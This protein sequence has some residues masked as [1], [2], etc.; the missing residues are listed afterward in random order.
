MLR[1]IIGLRTVPARR[2]VRLAYAPKHPCPVKACVK[3]KSI[4]PC[5]RVS[6][7]SICGISFHI[8]PPFVE[9]LHLSCHFCLIRRVFS[10]L[11]CLPSRMFVRPSTMGSMGTLDARTCRASVETV[12][13]ALTTRR[14]IRLWTLINA[15]VLFFRCSASAHMFDAYRSVEYATVPRIFLF[16]LDAPPTFGMRRPS[17]A[18]IFSAFSDVLRMCGRKVDPHAEVL[19]AR[20]GDDCLSSQAEAYFPGSPLAH[21]EHGLRFL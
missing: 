11:A 9:L 1:V 8:H 13:Y 4:C 21:Q 16:A 14:V 19:D 15:L 20:R 12:L 18:T 17:I 6:H 5:S 2:C 7:G 10:L 3:W